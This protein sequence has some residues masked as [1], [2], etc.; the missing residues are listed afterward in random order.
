MKNSVSC[1]KLKTVEII[2]IINLKQIFIYLL[3]TESKCLCYKYIS[4]YLFCADD[5]KNIVPATSIYL[6]F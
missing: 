4:F 5:R 3:K 6:L 1:L 2:T